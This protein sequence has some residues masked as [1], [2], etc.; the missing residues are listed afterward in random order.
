VDLS[1]ALTHRFPLSE[2]AAAL[3]TARD[4]EVAGKVLIEPGA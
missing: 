4:P 1:P 2:F 3:D